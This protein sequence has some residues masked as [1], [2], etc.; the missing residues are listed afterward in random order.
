MP[1]VSRRSATLALLSS[2]AL[3]SSCSG[4]ATAPAELEE[5]RLRSRVASILLAP[6]AAT[7]AV[8]GSIQ[9]TATVRNPYGDALS[10]RTITWSTSRA[11]VAAVN[12]SGYVQARG[13]GIA[14]IVAYVEGRADTT[15][16]TVSS[17]STTPPPPAPSP[18][19]AP[20]ASI[21]V[22]PSSTSLAVGSSLQFT[23]TLRD[24]AG[25]VLTGRAVSWASAAASIV[26]VSGTGVATGLLG[27]STTVLASAEGRSA[28]AP[29]TVNTPIAPPTAFNEPA[30][31]VAIVERPFLT[32]AASG[33]DRGTGSFPARTGGSEG[34]D[35][36][37]S[38]YSLLSIVADATAPVSPAGV[39]RFSYPAQT[40]AAGT[41]FSPGV[42][43][44]QGFA[45][46]VHGSL[47]YRR[48][49]ARFWF[50][51][52][53]G[54]QNHTT[55]TKLMFFRSSEING[56]KFE[57]IIA[58]QGQAGSARLVF[59]LQ[60]TQDNARGTLL[61]NLNTTLGDI[62]SMRADTWYRVEV[63]LQ[64]NSA[65]G[66]ADG[67][68]RGWLDGVEFFALRDVRFLRDGVNPYVWDNV[69]VSPTW[70]GQGGTITAGWSWYL[71]HLYVSGAP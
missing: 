18:A 56:A 51:L 41:T 48:L 27:G 34:W 11:E 10:G 22:T 16:I 60:G 65:Y 37:E 45:S 69:H 42:T 59:N 9:L 28:S 8:G 32:K 24:S 55:G 47:R 58:I 3:L 38:S 14:Y 61:P 33:A 31:M 63:L 39:M 19:P 57:P 53:A 68:L 2:I 49:Y 13:R 1:V 4:D 67:V 17:E 30:G 46:A 64:M 43:Q 12:G 7:L 20:V 62:S 25:N 44:T 15:V 40:V 23:A 26:S 6:Q 50:K 66:V 5:R 36:V 21:S 70:G 35:G 71:D 54:F 52:G 29:V